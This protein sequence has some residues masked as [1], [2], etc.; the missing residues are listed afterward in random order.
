M[1][2]LA[3][4]FA[5]AV[6]ALAA[7]IALATFLPPVNIGL[8]LQTVIR[9]ELDLFDRLLPR[10]PGD[11]INF[12]A[13]VAGFVAGLF[14]FWAIFYSAFMLAARQKNLRADAKR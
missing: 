4:S 14:F 12:K 3:G 13:I 1:R 10:A 9:W 8:L 2:R 5:C 11:M 6:A 7:F